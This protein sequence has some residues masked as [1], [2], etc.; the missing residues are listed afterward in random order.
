MLVSKHMLSPLT[1][2]M[3]QMADLLQAED[4][5]LALLDAE[6]NNQEKQLYLSSSDSAIPRYERIFAITPSPI[7]TIQERRKALIAKMNSRASATAAT[8]REIV[9]IITGNNCEIIEYSSE[10]RFDVSITLDNPSS[11][12]SLSEIHR[13]IDTL[14]PAH[15]AYN[16]TMTSTHNTLMFVGIS[17]TKYREE[18]I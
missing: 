6:I 4:T 8:L 1:L 3:S 5:E 2:K 13:Q 16:L 10:Y 14:K 17:M 15:L 7:A 18:Y 11:A 12:T 9:E